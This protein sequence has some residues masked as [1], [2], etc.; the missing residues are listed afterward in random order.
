M[1][2][3][4]LKRIES[5]IQASEEL[6][7]YTKQENNLHG[8]PGFGYYIEVEIGSPPQM[9]NILCDTG[10]SNFAV[11]TTP[12]PQINSH[13]NVSGSSTFKSSGNSVSVTYTQGYWKGVLGEDR[14]HLPPLG[15]ASITVNIACINSSTNFFINGSQWQG[16]LGL[17]YEHIA[18]PDSET[19][20]FFQSLV[21]QS[22][23][24]NTFALQLC[25]TDGR[26]NEV[27]SNVSGS[28]TLG[29]I[30]PNLYVGDIR[31]TPI[32]KA[33]YYEVV[34]TDLSVNE[35]SLGM[36]CK[37]YNFDKTIIDSGTTNLR[38]PDKVFDVIVKDI[39][40]KIGIH[41]DSKDIPELFWDGMDLLCWPPGK[42]PYSL[43]PDLNIY[44][45]ESAN[46][47][48]A[49]NVPPARYLRLMPGNSDLGAPE[50]CY[51]FAISPSTSGTVI[52]AVIMEGY[53]VIFDKGNKRIG[54][55]RTKCDSRSAGDQQASLS[56]PQPYLLDTSAFDCAYVKP[57]DHS[58]TLMTA[59][60][61]MAGI[62]GACLIPLILMVI[63]WQWSRCRVHT[64]DQT[65]NSGLLSETD[66]R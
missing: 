7:F 54:F 60:Y 16:I 42:T 9:L 63:Q 25:G 44:L 57:E 27:N 1:F 24:N 34:I 39:K 5:Q 64:D 26:V 47:T 19:K 41:E 53:Y 58:S 30:D 11:A 50:D 29:G 22:E 43:F 28:L 37:E 61:V 33:W 65:D 45:A 40:R 55:A 15:N 51:K 4:P 38:F 13:F 66:M 48:F 46:S 31:W 12:V 35:D 56:N 21:E 18:K 59:A 52:G 10:S 2:S 6:S 49:L 62:C 14:I 20:T 17:A 3:V 32:H 23:I 8:Q 36:D